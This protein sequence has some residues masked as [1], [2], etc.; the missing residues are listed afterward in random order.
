MH[1]QE[2]MVGNLRKEHISG[3]L[4]V[5][6]IVGLEAVAGQSKEM[7]VILELH[8]KSHWDSNQF[9]AYVMSEVFVWGL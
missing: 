9:I 2:L 8:K 5:L 4:A 3:N 6:G 1:T 7:A